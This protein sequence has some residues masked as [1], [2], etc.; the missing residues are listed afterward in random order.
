MF[1]LFP[2]FHWIL[3]FE[4][5]QIRV[6]TISPGATRAPGLLDLAGDDAVQRQGLADYPA[7]Q[8][9]MGRLGEPGEIAR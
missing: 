6:N 3:D 1:I 8:N 9:P 5:R 2:E 7:A 4:D